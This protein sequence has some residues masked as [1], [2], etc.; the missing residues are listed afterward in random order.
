MVESSKEAI[1]QVFK[2]FDK[3]GSGSLDM[4]EISL[5]A[6][7]LGHEISAQELKLIF[8]DI[9]SNKDNKISFDEFFVWWSFGRENK[10][11]KLVYLQLK[12]MNLL[13]K[14]KA[15]Y[16]KVGGLLEAKY[17]K[18]VSSHFF[19]VSLGSQ[20]SKSSISVKAVGGSG[21]PEFFN[22]K[23]GNS[24]IS[25]DSISVLF[26]FE[27]PNPNQAS[28]E[29]SALLDQIKELA[30]AMI[31]GDEAQALIGTLSFKTSVSGNH[32]VVAI[33]ND[34][35]LVGM[36]AGQYLELADMYTGGGDYSVNVELEVGAGLNFKDLLQNK[37]KK[38]PDFLDGGHHVSLNVNYSSNLASLIKQLVISGTERKIGKLTEQNNQSGIRRLVNRQFIYYLIN[39]SKV[40]IQFKDLNDLKEKSVG[41]PLQYALEKAESVSDI[42]DNFKKA[43]S[44]ADLVGQLPM[45]SELIEFGKNHMISNI[46]L[47]VNVP[48]VAV[49][50]GFKTEGIKEVVEFILS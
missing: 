32:V 11:E 3:D 13:N 27:S 10:L 8:A 45:A 7:E 38:L 29:I 4:N 12:A 17:N 41:T 15:A 14:A 28:T 36:M 22:S 9:D 20:E 24:G 37:E 5:V 42:L 18:D 19:N 34:H 25:S 50:I 23:S 39:S 26:R 49:S 44:P 43:A 1:R 16:N 47:I 2:A 48:K 6:K 35:P 33:E 30:S 46:E 31:P 21:H 40:N